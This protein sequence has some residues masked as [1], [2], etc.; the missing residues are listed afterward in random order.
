MR[1]EKAMRP[2]V[3][4]VVLAG[5]S[6]FAAL[7]AEAR[8]CIQDE[9]GR[10]VCGQPVAPDV[11]P[12]YRD[13]PQDRD[14]PAYGDNGDDEEDGDGEAYATAPQQYGGPYV[15]APGYGYG[16]YPAPSPYVRPHWQ[17]ERRGY[18]GLREWYPIGPR[19]QCPYNYT[20]Q[21]G[22]CEPYRGR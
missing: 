10:I 21:H 17:A 1:S 2:I 15:P 22:R 6:V 14:A 18:A 7:P 12:Q 3:A 8:V 11:A 4:A 13:A 5:G 16:R 9:G 19:G 20:I